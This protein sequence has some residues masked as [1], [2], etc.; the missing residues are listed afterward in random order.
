MD[1][2][3]QALWGGIVFGSVYGLMAVGLTLVW[4]AL[5]FLNFAHGVFYV[6]GGYLGW[7]LMSELGLPIGLALP[8]A[9]A[10]TALVGVVSYLAAV[11]PVLGK[12]G[13][14]NAT[15]ISTIAAGIVLENVALLVWG[16]R[17]KV[18]PE[19]VG[20]NTVVANVVVTHH[21]V[22]V[23]AVSVL[24]LLALQ[25]FLRRSRHGLAVRAVS[26]Q[27]DAARLMGVPVRRVFL[28]VMAVS[29]GLAAVAGVLLTPM[30]GLNPGAGFLPLL[31]ALTVVIL[32]GLGSVKGTIWAAAAVGFMESFVQVYVG[33][34]WTLP[35]LFF[36]VV[37]VLSARPQGFFGQVEMKRL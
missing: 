19:L 16:P 30:L 14:L 2:L 20:G 18:V 31:K 37:V 5:N 33:A 28:I 24:L 25:G 4:G 27:M 21:S 26:Q 10:G 9:V 7:T 22:A 17:N 8:L 15:M 35:I 11:Q 36:M 3:V 1:M 34:S 32:G 6:V 29:A 13:W 12:A 23:V